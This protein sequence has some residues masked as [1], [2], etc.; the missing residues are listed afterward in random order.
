MPCVVGNSICQITFIV[1]KLLSH[2]D[3]VL[4]IDWLVRWNPVIDWR[5]QSMYLY[6]NRQWDQVNVVLLDGTQS[7]VTVKIFEAYRASD[8]KEVPDWTIV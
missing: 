6:V 5:K 8:E 7:A 3:V 1:T 4:G 2:V